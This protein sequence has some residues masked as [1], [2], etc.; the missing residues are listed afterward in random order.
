MS[1]TKKRKVHTQEYKAKVALEALRSGKTI[2]QIG[3]EF[4]VH[5]VRGTIFLLSTDTSMT[6][7][8]ILQLYGY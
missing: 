7:L 6:A 3:Q 5:P 1:E 8:E 2:K 4:D